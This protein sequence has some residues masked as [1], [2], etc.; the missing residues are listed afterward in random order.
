[1]NEQFC[2]VGRGITLC[3]EAFGNPDDP[4][5]LLIMGLGTQMI[6]WP[7]PFCE[8]LAQRGFYVVRFD[9]RDCGRST[10]ARGKP[11]TI[12][13]LALRRIKDPPYTLSD[14]ADDAAR[15]LK[16]L[17]F[18]S[19]H[20]VGASMGGMIAQTLAIEHPELVRSLVSIMSTT[21]NR[22]KGQPKYSIL[23]FILRRAPTERDAFIEH[24]LTVFDAIGS[25]DLHRDR[26]RMRATAQ[27]S[28]ERGLN[29]AGTGRQLGASVAAA[30]RTPALRSLDVPA[31]VIHGSK[32]PMVNPNGG[33]ATAEAIPGARLLV[34]DGMGHDLPEE[35]WDRIV[36]AIA[37]L[38]QRAQRAASS[39]AAGD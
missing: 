32:D 18:S 12:R 37:E 1:M 27:L 38:A 15:L 25:P 34:V 30:D 35:A 3:Y 31:L 2:D 16:A 39:A 20:I 4:P 17:G 23:R 6:A 7:E 29:P 21:G 11:P 19:A 28:Y 8:A 14:L 13:E 24:M 36:E 26:D 22:W 9:N 10:R 33:R 5:M